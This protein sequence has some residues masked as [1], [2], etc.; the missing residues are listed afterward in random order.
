[1]IKE[2]KVCQSKLGIHD[3]FFFA[4]TFTLDRRWVI[5]LCQEMI[6]QNLNIKWACNSRPDS[7]DLEMAQKMKMAGCGV[8]SF[9]VESGKDRLLTEIKRGNDLKDCEDAIKVCREAGLKSLAFFMIGLPGETRQDAL[10]TIEFSKKLDPDFIEYNIAQTFPGTEMAI[11]LEAKGILNQKDGNVLRY[12]VTSLSEHMSLEEINKILKTAIFKF[13]F[14]PKYI[15]KTLRKIKSFGELINY[16]K[17]AFW[18]F[19]TFFFTKKT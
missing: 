7:I 9:G 18:R 8:V 12:K 6:D 14:R 19:P 4:D 10:E 3:F 5:T 13:H 1:M 16:I 11:D 17:H 15:L 2:I